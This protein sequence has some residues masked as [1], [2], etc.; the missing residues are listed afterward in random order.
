MYLSY[1]DKF[2]GMTPYL[3]IDEKEWSYIKETFEKS[4]EHLFL[5][6]QCGNPLKIFDNTAIKDSIK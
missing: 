1:F 2:L 6:P 4:L 5:C 3:S